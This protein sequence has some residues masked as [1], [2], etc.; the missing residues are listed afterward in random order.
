LTKQASAALLRPVIFQIFSENTDLRPA[1]YSWGEVAA[2]ARVLVYLQE[3]VPVLFLPEE[4]VDT[5]PF[6][7]QKYQKRPLVK[8]ILT[9]QDVR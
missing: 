7:F 4:I 5:I 3:E 1:T 9:W 8:G 6:R 2:E